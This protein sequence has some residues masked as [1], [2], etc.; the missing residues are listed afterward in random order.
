[1]TASSNKNCTQCQDLQK[2]KENANPTATNKIMFK[3]QLLWM[4]IDYFNSERQY[5]QKTGG[6]CTGRKKE[7]S[8]GV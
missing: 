5:P 6:K 7:W 1:M 3:P 2:F 4:L 8:R